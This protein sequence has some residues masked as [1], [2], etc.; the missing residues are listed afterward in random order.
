[1][2]TTICADSIKNAAIIFSND[3]D[4]LETPFAAILADTQKV[5]GGYIYAPTGELIHDN[6][7]REFYFF[8][9]EGLTA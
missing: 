1:M 3:G 4:N 9:S 5:A 2:P 6:E 8:N 7:K